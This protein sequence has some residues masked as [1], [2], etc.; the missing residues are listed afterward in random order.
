MINAWQRFINNVKLRRFCVLILIIFI[1]WL[2]RSIMSIVLLTFIFTFLVVHL[3]HFIQ[4]YFKLPSVLIVIVTYAVLFAALYFGITNYLPKLITQIVRMTT[5]LID[6]Y[7]NPDRNTYELFKFVTN[8]IGSSGITEQFKKGVGLVFTYITSVGSMGVTFVL[9]LILSF[10]YSI[11]L[12]QMNS[13]SHLFLDS[14]FGWFFQDLAFFGHKFVNTFGVVLEAQFFIAI[15][16]TAITTVILIFMG[17]PQIMALAIMIF[18]L[19]LIPVAGVIVSCIPLSI[20]GYSV[21]GI[22]DV[23]YILIMITAVH[24]L[25]A[26]VLNPKFMSSRTE[27]PIFYTFVVLLVSERLFGV[28]GLIVGVPIFTFLLDILGVKSIP[29]PKRRLRRPHSKIKPGN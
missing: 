11:E 16:N 5:S 23:V 28:W 4:R 14:E 1:L 6:F 12:K 8:Y 10:F 15:C 18:I 24:M 20:I 3:V 7:Q 26:Y 29:R 22:R 13:F 9:S 17:M 21:G 27:L 19:S 2:A 25:E